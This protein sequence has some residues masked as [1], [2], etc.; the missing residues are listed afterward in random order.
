MIDPDEWILVAYLHREPCAELFATDRGHKSTDLPS[1]SIPQL[2]FSSF[3]SSRHRRRGF[4][5]SNLIHRVI[6]EPVLSK[7]VNLDALT[8]AG[9]LEN[10]LSVA[11]H[12]KY[13]FEKIDLRDKS[14]VLE[15]VRR[16]SITHVMHLAA[17]S[18][19][20][21]SI[22]GPGDF[23]QTNVAGTFH[24]LEA[25]RAFWLEER[26]IEHDARNPEGSPSGARRPASCRLFL[27][28]STDEVF[29]SLGPVGR[30]TEASPYEPNSPYAASKA[31]GDLLVRAWNQTLRP[32]RC[33]H[34][35]LK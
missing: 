20:D 23:I 12:R 32:A 2:T 8:Y 31:S 30:F 28:V 19:V 16:H 34:S 5:G 22:T 6:D 1:D 4:V 26:N 27:H 18:H 13:I 33:H 21:R 14:A 29:G 3:E 17:E 10:L 25:C 24:L 15:V 9:H 7:L 11:S 35:L